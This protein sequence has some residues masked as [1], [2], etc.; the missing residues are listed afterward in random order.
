M[1]KN[2][3]QYYIFLSSYKDSK[4]LTFLTSRIQVEAFEVFQT[5]NKY[6]I[7]YIPSSTHRLTLQLSLLYEHVNC[8]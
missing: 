1:N 2:D 5:E 7:R 4:Q 6:L 3:Q 8:L